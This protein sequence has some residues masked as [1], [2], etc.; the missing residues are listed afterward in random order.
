VFGQKGSDRGI[1]IHIG[2]V[3]IVMIPAYD[4]QGGKKEKYP[5]GFAY[6]SSVSFMFS[7]VR[8]VNDAGNRTADSKPYW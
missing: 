2:D 8:A 6:I 4:I 5:Y 1:L 3:P 7:R